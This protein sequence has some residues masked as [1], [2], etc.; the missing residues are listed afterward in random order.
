MSKKKKVEIRQYANRLEQIQVRMNEIT[1]LCEKENRQRTDAENTEFETLKREA[2]IINAR[3]QAANVNGG[4]V[5]V[6]DQADAL[7]TFLRSRIIDDNGTVR[8]SS[9]VLHRDYTGMSTADGAAAVPLTIGDIVKP[10]EAGL[11]YNKIGIPLLTGLSGD[12]CW[13]VVGSVEATIQGEAVELTD[14]KIDIDALKPKPVRLG[15]AIDVTNQT[16]NQTSGVV[17]QIIQQQ[18]PLAVAR[19]INRCM[20]VTATTDNGYHKDFHGPFVGSDAKT[21]SFSG[22]LPTYKELLQMRGKVFADGVENDGTGAY[23][24]S[25]E[26]AAILE[27]TSRDAGSGLMIIEDGKIGGFPVFQTSHI[28]GIGFGVFGLEPLGQFGEMRFIVDPYTKAGQDVTRL[29]LNA[30]WSM[31]TLRKEAFCL[32]KFKTTSGTQG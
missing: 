23:I 1:D 7:D 26:V 2:T 28:S 27:G 13:P 15:I 14:T 9:Y 18:M 5:E 8:Q 21:I 17:L 24:M 11:I 10:L 22:E 25:A 20:F 12:Y 31:S 29:I 32:G 16:I 4:F 6:S 3:I 30:D 19:L